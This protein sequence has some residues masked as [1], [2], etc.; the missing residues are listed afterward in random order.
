MKLLKRAISPRIQVPKKS[1]S[2]SLEESTGEGVTDV[3]F[4]NHDIHGNDGR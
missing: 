2:I 1:T 3:A 4:P